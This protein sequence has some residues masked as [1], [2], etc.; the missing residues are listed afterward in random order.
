MKKPSVAAPTMVSDGKVVVAQF[1][2]NDA[3]CL[4]LK[5]NLKWLR[6]LTYDYLNAANGLGMSSS[7]VIANGVLVAQ[8]ENDAES[9]TVGLSLING[10]TLWKKDRPRERTGLLRPFLAR[11]E[12][13]SRSSIN[14]GDRGH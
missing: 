10:T 14:E 4:D 3:F 11:K 2:S 5:G 7:P 13:T 12:S 1:S 9:F 8:V 6:G